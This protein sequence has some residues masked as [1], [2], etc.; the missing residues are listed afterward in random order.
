V[1]HGVI[2]FAALSFEG[3]RIYVVVVG[4]VVVEGYVNVD[5]MILIGYSGVVIFPCCCWTVICDAVVASTS[6]GGVVLIRFGI[7]VRS[8]LAYGSEI[9]RACRRWK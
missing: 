7:V 3:A 6:V 2:V 9:K 1:L 8:L 5:V 4:H